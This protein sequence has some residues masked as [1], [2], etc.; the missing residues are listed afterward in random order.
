MS[1]ENIV[2]VEEWVM[3]TWTRLLG[4]RKIKENR[5]IRTW[6]QIEWGGQGREGVEAEFGVLIGKML[7]TQKRKSGLGTDLLKEM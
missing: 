4:V 7:L 6:W 1:K 5:I 3:G 2:L